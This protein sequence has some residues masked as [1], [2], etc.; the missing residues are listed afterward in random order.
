M[1]QGSLYSWT[2]PATAYVVHLDAL[3]IVEVRKQGEEVGLYK[4][5]ASGKKRGILLPIDVWQTL[6]KFRN[7]INVAVDLSVGTLTSDK[8]A[9]TVL[10]NQNSLVSAIKYIYPNNGSRLHY[11]T[12]DDR[13]QHQ[14][15]HFSQE[16]DTSSPSTVGQHI[17]P[18]PGC[19]GANS[20]QICRE[21]IPIMEFYRFEGQQGQQGTSA[22]CVQPTTQ[23]EA[24]GNVN[25]YCT[26]YIC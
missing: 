22:G 4:L 1:S 12:D 13:L 19:S 14:A 17:S 8:V 23:E 3:H 15:A 5:T 11:T 18:N 20:N 26:P 21:T 6:G 16:R 7:L 9:E 24:P 2:Q 10:Q 25:T